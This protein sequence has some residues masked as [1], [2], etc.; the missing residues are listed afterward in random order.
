[1]SMA[2]AEAMAGTA[3][4]P[5]R[6]T[7]TF[8]TVVAAG[9]VVSPDVLSNA[10]PGGSSYSISDLFA[11][12]QQLANPVPAQGNALVRQ[13]EDVE[14]FGRQKVARARLAV[15]AA[16]RLVAEE[17]LSAS[18]WM[19]VRKE[20]KPDRSFGVA[21]AAALN[22]LRTVVPWQD[23]N[24]PELPT[25]ELVHAFMLGTPASAFMGR[26]ADD[27]RIGAATK[28]AARKVTRNR[29]KARGTRRVLRMQAGE[30]V[31]VRRRP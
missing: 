10:P 15:D 6:L 3:Q 23:D 29:R 13:V 8:F 19:E 18:Y 4:R 7:D 16:L 11:E 21:P 14:G 25:A 2:L 26:D 12:I 28:R 9:D 20:Q 27:P 31:A 24:R 17:L 5:L 30:P 22:A 1:L